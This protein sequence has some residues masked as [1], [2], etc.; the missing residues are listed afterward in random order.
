MCNEDLV[1]PEFCDCVRSLKFKSVGTRLAL[2]NGRH[3]HEL[4]YV[5]LLVRIRI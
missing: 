1:S 2:G 5:V 4:V 3:K